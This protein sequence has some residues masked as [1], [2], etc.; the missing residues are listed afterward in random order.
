MSCLFISSIELDL[1]IWFHPPFASKLCMFNLRVENRFK[2][3]VGWIY[4]SESALF[5]VVSIRFCFVFILLLQEYTL[6]YIK[7]KWNMGAINIGE[8]RDAYNIGH[9]QHQRK[10][11]E[12]KTQHRKLKLKGWAAQIPQQSAVKPSSREGQIM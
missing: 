10:T 11:R 6:V 2:K 8:S 1:F 4:A 9:T 5:S 12:A 7:A 3:F